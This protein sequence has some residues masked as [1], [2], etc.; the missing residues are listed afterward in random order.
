[1]NED[2][3]NFRLYSP[4]Y[5]YPQHLAAENGFQLADGVD[6][7]QIAAYSDFMERASG[8]NSTGYS[9]TIPAFK[10]GNPKVDNVGTSPNAF[11]LSLFN[12]KYVI[13]EF[14]IENRDLQEII[15][16]DHLFMYENKYLSER[17]WVEESPKSSEEFQGIFD[18]NIN[19]LDLTPNRIEILAQGPG[20]LVLSEVQYPGWKVDVDGNR[21]PIELAYGLLRSVNLS[22]GD[23]EVEFYFRP[24]TVYIGLGM[25]MIGW[26]LAIW[27]IYG[28]ED[29]EIQEESLI[30]SDR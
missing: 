18:G 28:K 24:L 27:Q 23:H 13:S 21:Q 12:V 20:R 2:Q 15:N 5:S 22:E 3:E 1:M 6:P 10:S 14:E 19:E 26:I 9:V 7:M 4:S 11:L 25:T 29:D 8:V 16:E 17:A 30:G